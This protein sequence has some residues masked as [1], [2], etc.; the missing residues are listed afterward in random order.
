MKK[1]PDTLRIYAITFS[2][3][4]YLEHSQRESISQSSSNDSKIISQHLYLFWCLND[5][6]FQFSIV[7]NSFLVLFLDDSFFVLAIKFQYRTFYTQRYLI[8]VRGQY[9][10]VISLQTSL[11]LKRKQTFNTQTFCVYFAPRKPLMHYIH[12][13]RCKALTLRFLAH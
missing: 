4:E 9:Y 3:L 12:Q 6:G 1:Y 11:K 10:A 7:Q 8:F 2:K 5:L 13:V